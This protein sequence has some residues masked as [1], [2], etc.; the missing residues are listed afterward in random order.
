MPSGRR[1][2]PKRAQ[3]RAGLAEASDADAKNQLAGWYYFGRGGAQDKAEAVRWFRVAAEQGHHYLEPHHVHR[4]ADGG[5]DDPVH[6]IAL[7]PNCHR[8]VHYGK[9]G[10]LYNT[11][12]V[13][14][15]KKI[16][17]HI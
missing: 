17:L 10:T 6:V 13:A 5:P 15:L 7:C 14:K 9:N 16:D 12:L 4:L 8:R 3:S 11:E 1:L 2:N